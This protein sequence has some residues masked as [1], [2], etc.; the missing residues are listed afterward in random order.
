MPT[1]A[2]VNFFEIK[3][4]TAKE[5]TWNKN[6]ILTKDM[7][8]EHTVDGLLQETEYMFKVKAHFEDTE[9][10][11]SD[12]SD[13]IRTRQS[14]ASVLKKACMKLQDGQ[15]AFYKLPLNENIPA[16]NEQFKT[17]KLELGT[18]LLRLYL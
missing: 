1:S 4:K 7:T 18:F 17:R 12:E 6:T 8:P 2:E 3:Y 16:R 13:P 11:Y 15:P 5:S 9:S 14:P 10:E